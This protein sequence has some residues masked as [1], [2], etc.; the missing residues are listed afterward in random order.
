[1]ENVKIEQFKVNN[2]VDDHSEFSNF[3][4]NN[5]TNNG[6]SFISSNRQGLS[7]NTTKSYHF[8]NIASYSD[9]DELDH[10]EIQ[11][12]QANMPSSNTVK[13]STIYFTSNEKG[14]NSNTPLSNNKK[15]KKI[16]LISKGKDYHSKLQ[17]KNCGINLFV[18]TFKYIF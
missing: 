11:D 12:F 7:R 1:M 10:D 4:Q 16:N 6:N 14:N 17:C 13:R 9:I 15:A 5:N 18:F 2:I 3:S 8:I